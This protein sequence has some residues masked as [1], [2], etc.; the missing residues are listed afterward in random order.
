MTFFISLVAGLDSA[1]SLAGGTVLHPY[2]TDVHNLNRG[3]IDCW[4][5]K[6]IV[7]LIMSNLLIVD[8]RIMRLRSLDSL[9]QNLPRK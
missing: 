1:D 7:K 5:G 6:E 3:L 2:S 8:V 9:P 4:K